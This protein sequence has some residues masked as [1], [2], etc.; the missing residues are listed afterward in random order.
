MPTTPPT[1]TPSTAGAAADMNL[2]R[3]A[4]LE[5]QASMESLGA[6]AVKVNRTSAQSIPDDTWT[7]VSFNN[8]LLDIGGWWSSG[9]DVIMP[10]DF[11]AGI[12]AHFV[13]LPLVAVFASNATGSRGVRS[14]LDG[15]V[16]EQYTFDASVA[17]ATTCAVT[18]SMGEVEEAGVITMEVYQNSGGALNLSGVV[19]TAIRQFP[20]A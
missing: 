10:S 19:L 20:S 16:V 12:T 7:E 8:Q 15:S 4:I 17:G 6:S 9:T 18:T 2:I 3:D 13:L 14:L 11:A 5:L 1:F